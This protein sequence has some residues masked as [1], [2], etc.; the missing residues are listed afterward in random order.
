MR[1]ASLLHPPFRSRLRAKSIA[2]MGTPAGSSHS[3]AIALLGHPLPP[4]VALV[5]P[6]AVGEDRAL[7]ARQRR[8]EHGQLPSTPRQDVLA[9][10]ASLDIVEAEGEKRGAARAVEVQ[11]ERSRHAA[12]RSIKLGWSTE[13]SRRTQARR[14][15]AT[16]GSTTRQPWRGE[17][18]LSPRAG[19]IAGSPDYLSDLIEGATQRVG[20]ALDHRLHGVAGDIG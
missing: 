1:P 10:L 17:T 18:A 20:V 15:R 2:S 14:C 5:G 6:R 12:G 19:A 7:P 11:L 3:G 13:P 4:D 8:D 16:P 9:W